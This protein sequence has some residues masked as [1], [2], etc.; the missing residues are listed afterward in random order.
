MT[1]KS[2]VKFGDT[3]LTTTSTVALASERSVDPDAKIASNGR[4]SPTNTSSFRS[5]VLRSNLTRDHKD[6]DPL[7][8]YEVLQLLGVGSMGSVVKVRKRGEVVGGSSRKDLQGTFQRERLVHGCAKIPFFGWIAQHCI[9]NPLKN[10][11]QQL[12]KSTSNPMLNLLSLR[13]NESPFKAMNDSGRSL[14]TNDSTGS[15]STGKFEYAMKSI[16]LSRVTD[17][18]FVE[19]LRNEVAVLKA[20]DHPHIGLL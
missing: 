17:I 7:F 9:K 13:S 14:D 12:K 19:E 16:H 1:K 18:V 11:E 6:R 8:Y 5:A 10:H 4:D 3:T 15:S 20:L 2:V